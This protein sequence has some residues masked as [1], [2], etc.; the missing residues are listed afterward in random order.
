MGAGGMTWSTGLCSVTFRALDVDQVVKLAAD[1]GLDAIEWGTDVHAPPGDTR[2]AMRIAQLCK[3]AGLSCPTLGSYARATDSDKSQPI[4]PVLDT[5][6]AI[7]SKTIRVWAGETGFSKADM[8]ERQRIADRVRGY[9]EQAGARGMKIALEYHPN[10]LTDCRE[11]AVWLLNA[12]AHPALAS[13]WQ[14]VPDQPVE[15]CRG[16]LAALGDRLAHIHVFFWKGD[17]VRHPLAEGAG[18]WADI[19]SGT[20]VPAGG[21]AFLEFVPGDDPG[22]LKREA[23]TLAELLA[24]AAREPETM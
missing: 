19:L 24:R 10:T 11:G 1:A 13:Y 23:A 9:A 8:S 4:G 12:A 2:N 16:D 18:Y 20:S 22:I 7:G 3:D 17:F 21:H 15:T 14:P 6:E 5:A